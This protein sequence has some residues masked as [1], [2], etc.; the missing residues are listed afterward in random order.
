VQ[1]LFYISGLIGT[2]LVSLVAGASVVCTPGFD[3]SQFFPWLADFHPTWYT[4]VPAVHQAILARAAMHHEIITRYPLRFI[5][6]GS[7]VLPP[8]VRA[9]LEEAFNVPVIETYG[10]TEVPGQITGNPLPPRERKTGSVGVA[11]GL[12]VAVMN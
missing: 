10:M 6:S 8:Q 11:V 9:G 7:A 5:R 4:A 2:V 1:P 12:K 3:A